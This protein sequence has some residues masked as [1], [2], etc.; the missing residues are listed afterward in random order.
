MNGIKDK[1]LDSKILIVDD[2]SDNIDLLE[3]M[4]SLA[5]YTNVQSTTDPRE[6]E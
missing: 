4:L 1:A 6:V 2:K 5:G 3:M